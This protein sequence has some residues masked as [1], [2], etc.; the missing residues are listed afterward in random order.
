MSADQEKF[1][2]IRETFSPRFMFKDLEAIAGNQIEIE[3]DAF[4]ERIEEITSRVKPSFQDKYESKWANFYLP[5]NREGEL[6]CTAVSIFLSYKKS[7][8]VSFPDISRYGAA[9]VVRGADDIP[10]EYAAV[11]DEAS[12]FMPFVKEHG[13]ELVSVFHPYEWRTGRIR[14]KYTCDPSSLIS[15]EEGDALLAAYE[16]HLEKKPALTEISLN[17]Y[18]N[19]AA[20]CYRAAFPEDIER[21]E[22]QEK[23]TDL[24]GEYLHK[25]WADGRHGGMLFLKDRDSKK[26]YM[27]WLLSREW[28]GAH[29]FEIVYSGNIHGITLYPPDNREK[30]YRLNVVDPFYNAETLKMVAALIE[31]V[32]PFSTYSLGELVNYCRGE[33]HINVNNFSMRG[34]WFQYTDEE[35]EREQYFSYIE[36]DEIQLLEEG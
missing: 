15:R 7:L 36:W 11:L 22:R 21:F 2:E 10:E 29:P 35:D 5:V 8:H 23:R 26:E 27:D 12:R 24:S 17:D 14:R 9:A 33:S 16:R 4:Y 34:D 25:R 32:V 31:H 19:T 3:S 30:E 20:I 18:L 28:E 6:I 13:K 1:N